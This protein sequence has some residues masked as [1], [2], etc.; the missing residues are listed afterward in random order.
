MNIRLREKKND[1]K[2]KREEGFAIA[3]N[4]ADKGNELA[5]AG[6]QIKKEEQVSSIYYSPF[7]LI[8]HIAFFKLNCKICVWN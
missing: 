5:K 6:I 7:C 1:A 8:E 2:S 4:V 3:Q